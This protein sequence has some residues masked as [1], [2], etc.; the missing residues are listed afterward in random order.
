MEISIDTV[1][2]LPAH[3]Y[4]SV[5]YGEVRKQAPFRA[6]EVISFAQASA[7]GE[8]PAKAYSVDV[9]RK[10]GSKQVSLAGITALDGV[11]RSENLLIPSLEIQGMPVTASLT[12]KLAARD[13]AAAPTGRRDT[14]IAQKAKNYLEK[15]GLQTV[16][17][18]MFSKLLDQQPSDPFN[19]MIEA[20][21]LKR[22]EA[23]CEPEEPPEYASEPG[24]GTGPYPGFAAGRDLPDLTNHHSLIADILRKDQGIYERLRGQRTSLGI[25]VAAC[26]KPGVDCPGH[27]LVKVAGVFAGDEESYALFREVFDPVI[28]ASHPGWEPSDMHACD[29]DPEKLPQ[30][31][32]DPTG[33]YAVY[34]S[35]EVRRNF[36]GIPLPTCCSWSERRQVEGLVLAAMEKGGAM[37]GTYFPLRYSDSHAAKEGGMK[38]Y[39]EDRLRSVGM[40]FN[41]PDSRLRLSAGVGRD[42]P[43]ARGVFV[44]DAQGV[45]LW[46]NE[47]DHLRFFMRQHVVDLKKCW[48]SLHKTVE[49]LA[50]NAG[51]AYSCTDRLGYTTTCP[52]RLGSALRVSV[53]LKIPLLAATADLAALC[54]LL[55]VVSGQEV[56]NP[57]TGKVWN[58]T[59]DDCLGVS[60]VALI[61]GMIG[62]CATLVELEKRLE[63]GEP[64]YDAMP[65]LG[66]QASPG[67]PTDQCPETMPTLANSRSVVAAILQAEPGIYDRL[68]QLKTPLDV[69]LAQCVKPA[70]DARG[71]PSADFTGL[72]AGDEASF[73]TF[74]ELFD[75]VLSRLHGSFKPEGSHPSDTALAGLAEA[76]EKAG[77]FAQHCIT[78]RVEL[79]RNLRGLRLA[80]CC[81]QD[82]RREVER[83]LS[84]AMFAL[85]DQ[86]EG[87][88]FP[89]TSSGSY[90]PRPGGTDSAVQDQLASSGLIFKE[91]S[92]AGTLAAGVGRH[93]PDARGA[94]VARG[95]DLAVWCNEEDHVRV[96]AMGPFDL[97]S[98]FCKAS[99]CVEALGVCFT[100][101]ERAYMHSERLGFLTVDPTHLGAGMTATAVMRLPRLTAR[102]DFQQVCQALRLKAAWRGDAWEVSSRPGLGASEATLLVELHEGCAKLSALEG[103]LEA[104][105]AVEGALPTVSG[106]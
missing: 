59:S 88:Y 24:L 1:D 70:F 22:E 71:Q 7:P 68:K 76:A 86:V 95:G 100:A 72:V 47:E 23:N 46:C 41:D 32:I 60:E 45:Y 53:C 33:K 84:K 5:R 97:G 63:S 13:G 57:T 37:G 93:W 3:T 25:D 98:A 44:G 36:S 11:V 48:A 40:L 43:D 83:L 74:R 49:A 79:R 20:L 61:E 21:M 78:V 51:V 16:L 10:V 38:A 105:R 18:E 81:T 87:E 73:E 104:G 6:G 106:S 14:V 89:L 29:A 27:E 39:E 99:A 52:S 67:F 28:G 56:E 90:A 82:E 50:E 64:I 91:P 92:S 31:R 54:R 75:P 77:S 34:A 12:A 17:H 62:A 9:F 2:A 66:D 80:P 15:H 101:S 30:T 26:I 102:P 94:F 4:V 69:N 35:V 58:I 19:F 96:F 85:R 55:H 8:K 103:Q 65:G 42:W